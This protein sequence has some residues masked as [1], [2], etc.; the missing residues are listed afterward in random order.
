MITKEEF[1]KEY[2]VFVDVVSDLLEVNVYDADG[3]FLFTD[4]EKLDN[5]WKQYKIV[6][7]MSEEM[8]K[9]LFSNKRMEAI[10]EILTDG[11]KMLDEMREMNIEQ[12][13]TR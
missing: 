4:N 5:A 10:E 1:F 8:D 2:C 12:I 7:K 3:M 9:N 11:E 13:E 6:K